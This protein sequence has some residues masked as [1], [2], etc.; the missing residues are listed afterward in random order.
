MAVRFILGR[1]GTGKTCRCIRNITETLL[2]QDQ[3]P[4]ILLVPEQ[5][6]YQA[7]RA[8]L[9]DGRIGGYSR[10][11]VLSFNRL[12]F[13][14][15]GRRMALGSL[16]RSGQEMAVE[17]IL[18]QHK[19]KLRILGSS[20]HLSGLA[21][22][23]TRTLGELHQCEMDPDDVAALAVSLEKQ[24]GRELSARK[25]ADIAVV[26]RYYREFLANRFINPDMELSEARKAVPTAA[27]LK[28][29]RLWVDGFA[30]FTRQELELL[31]ELLKTAGESEIAL[32]L[33]PEHLPAECKRENLDPTSLFYPTEN[34]YLEMVEII[35]KCGLKMEEPVILKDTYRFTSTALAQVEKHLFANEPA[36]GLDS[37]GSIRVLAG[38]DQRAEA[39][40]AA[41]EI[42]RLV[43]SGWHYRDI[44]V[45]APDVGTYRH[46]IEAAFRDC[47]I[48]FFIDT[49]RRL[50]EH[51][52]ARGVLSALGA[53]TNGFANSDV[54]AFLK[55]GLG[56]LPV[57]E[58]NLLEN[59][60]IACGAG[61]KD[62]TAAKP[63]DF[64]VKGTT[65]FDN[66]KVDRIRKDAARP[67]MNLAAALAGPDGLL[68]PQ[69]FTAAVFGLI[70]E[71]KVR[72]TLG[73]WNDDGEEHRRFFDRF[74]GL[75]DELVTVLAGMR[76]DAGQYADVLRSAVEGT[77]LAL[78]PPR[79]DQ[80]LVGAIER[81]RHPDLK[82]VI[83][84]GC[85]QNAFPSPVRYGSVLTDD[86]RTAVEVAGLRL[87][88]TIE[89]QLAARQYLAYIAL[90][91]ASERLYLTYPMA[92]AKGSEAGRSEFID[93]IIKLFPDIHEEF[94][95]PSN[96]KA[97]EVPGEKYLADMLCAQLGRDAE[98][99]ADGKMLAGLLAG[100]KGQKEFAG[101]TDV[102]EASLAYENDAS[103]DKQA[104]KDAFATTIHS[105]VTRL[106]SFAACP[107]QHFARYVLGLEPRAQFRF[108]PLDL[109]QLYHTILDKLTRQL[110]ASGWLFGT[111][112][113]SGLL[114]MLG[115]IIEKEF[116]SNAF[117]ASFRGRSPHNM[118]IV[119]EAVLTLEE[120]VKAMAAA[121]RAGNLRT[122]ASEL[123]FGDA[124]TGLPPLIIQLGGGRSIYLRGK[125][126][127][128]DVAQDGGITAAFV[129]DYKTSGK[130]ISWSNIYHGLDLQLP[131]YLLAIQGRK[132][133]DSPPL[134]AAGA[135]FFPISTALP[136]AMLDDMDSEKEDKF[137]Y[138]AYGLFDGERY[139][140]LDVDSGQFSAFYNFS[141]TQKDAQYGRYGTSGAI[142]P[143]DYERLLA[144][145]QEKITQLAGQ[146]F[147]GRIEVHP[148]RIADESPCSN[149]DYL[150]VCRFDWQVNDY[151]FLAKVDKEE[152]LKGLGGGNG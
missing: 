126:D 5:A 113:E 34:T 124:K 127:R 43:R 78:I 140:L 138:K 51:P 25:F 60:C 39:E 33:D 57:D 144:F 2:R 41:A 101:V 35:R 11:S 13:M 28:N 3:R 103:L 27:F 141:V 83:L 92:D 26:Y 55:A 63:W 37:T 45:V 53:A 49:P 89:T 67:L 90:T 18:S 85:S 77:T 97:D 9:A 52:V 109:G 48:P 120:C 56:P 143:Q 76:M 64:A 58:V 91:R 108:E 130:S 54:F 147:G 14:L 46:Y 40:F 84:V 105:S 38:F 69:E 88:E 136:K 125:I 61:G 50:N 139:R 99:G 123:N 111:I 118:F 12:G 129:F 80:V 66:A 116:V 117:V 150:T 135:F 30:G 23:L 115:S 98:P 137:R 47:E 93:S 62:W 104:A 44:A 81:S 107:Y 100:L 82:A 19:D 106:G 110:I 68:G 6:S 70:E 21:R 133:G 36:T 7:E 1:S 65:G 86:D 142:K 119:D 10:L 128:L 32:C 72:T 15:L 75:F 42:R 151:N 22:E 132:L 148:Y 24:P 96:A 152:V 4:L 59:Y 112:E 87:G 122:V 145:V 20:S 74:V 94:I 31:V 71:M 8:I 146:M 131:T 73:T 29:A 79:L 149:C 17:A 121:S 134:T 114:Q 16:S 102:V 95:K